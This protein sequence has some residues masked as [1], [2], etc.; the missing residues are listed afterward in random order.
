M[1]AALQ[2]DDPRQIGPF[3]LLGRLGAGGMGHVFLGRAASGALVA[4]KSVRP[5]LAGNP[6]FRERFRHEVSAARRV[7]SPFTVRLVDADVAGAVPWLATAYIGGPSLADAVL[8]HGPLPVPSVLVLAAGLAEGLAAT[9]AADVV[10]RDL[11]PSNVLLAADGPRLIDFGVSRAAET[12]ALTQ[13]GLILGS[14]GFLSPEQAEGRTVGPASDVFSLGAVITFAATGEGPFGTGASAALLYRVVYSRPFLGRLPAEIRLLTERCLA[15]DPAH[16]PAIKELQAELGDRAPAGAAA[17]WLPEPVA[18]SLHGYQPP[19]RG[20]VPGRAV[21]DRGATPGGAVPGREVLPAAVAVRAARLPVPAPGAGSPVSARAA[22]PPVPAAAAARRPARPL[23]RKAPAAAGP[24]RRAGAWSRRRRLDLAWLTV[25]SG[26]AAAAVAVIVL[27]SGAGRPLA[28][29]PE[30]SGPWLRP[31][32]LQPEATGP[33]RQRASQGDSTRSPGASSPSA[34]APQAAPSASPKAAAP[35]VAVAA[36]PGQPAAIRAVRHTPA[37]SVPKPPVPHAVTAVAAGGYA[38]RVSWRAP[39]HRVSGFHLDNGCPPGACGGGGASL[40][41]DTGRVT[42]AVFAVTPGTTECF[43]VRAVDRHRVSAWSRYACA[44][45]PG[46]VLPGGEEWTDTGV[47]LRA[48][49]RVGITAGGQL[50]I[51]A[52]AASPGAASPAIST[53]DAIAHSVTVTPAGDTSCTP[54][55][56]PG[57][58]SDFPAPQLPCW[59]LVGRIG[60]GPA[61]GIGTSTEVTATA[62]RL[63]LA[64]N[65]PASTASTGSWTVNIKRGGMPSPP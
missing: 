28:Q 42:S 57:R 64:V 33:A 63:Y 47:T 51:I 65:K 16:R 36:R 61:F 3:Q 53:V 45:T 9:H 58:S 4:V 6:E 12:S 13:T 25:T 46:L 18:V 21:P 56:L 50:T 20:V 26:L 5:D 11:K 31:Y 54:A 37:P 38:I 2:P 44:S 49:D 40:V 1:L 39:L 22:R 7:E 34:V 52:G 62:G 60:G 10:H 24:A 30:V 35:S 27:P 8:E 48:G 17:Q 32:L 15:K 29:Q 41:M 59:S 14:P 55:A 43:R 19:E 23:T